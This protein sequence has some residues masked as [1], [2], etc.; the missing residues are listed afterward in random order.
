M[1]SRQ[2]I[3]HEVSLLIAKATEFPTHFNQTSKISWTVAL[4]NGIW[5]LS[6]AVKKERKLTHCSSAAQN[7]K[8]GRF[9]YAYDSHS[10]DKVWKSL[11]KVFFFIIAYLCYHVMLI[12]LII[13]ITR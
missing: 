6:A 9:R 5:L 11:S 8:I 3:L 12:K 7:I 10:R 4:K 1:S 13:L 2:N